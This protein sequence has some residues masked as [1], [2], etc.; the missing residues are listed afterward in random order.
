MT[1]DVC[2]SRQPAEKSLPHTPHPLPTT[3]H[4]HF[5][6]HNSVRGLVSVQLLPVIRTAPAGSGRAKRTRTAP[7]NTH[8]LALTTIKDGVL[9]RLAS[10][11]SV[12]PSLSAQSGSIN[13]NSTDVYRRNDS[14]S[15]RT[16]AMKTE[17]KILQLLSATVL[18]LMPSRRQL[19][20]N[21]S[22]STSIL[23]LSKCI[24]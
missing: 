17:K 24:S 13:L 15:C 2:V 8:T 10:S 4:T 6:R 22:Q 5:L 19:I 16:M 1:F 21:D 12:S 7:P 11:I 9:K 14:H 23:F 18:F 20:M 3:T